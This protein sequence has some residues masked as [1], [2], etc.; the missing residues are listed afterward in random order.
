MRDIPKM[1]LMQKTK[2]KN[3]IK[4]GNLLTKNVKDK[5]FPQ[6]KLKIP[7]ETIMIGIP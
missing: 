5:D 6:N 4:T 7:V 3:K 2:N 1:T